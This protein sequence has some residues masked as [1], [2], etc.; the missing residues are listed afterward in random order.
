MERQDAS[1]RAEKV[2]P[3]R[4]SDSIDQLKE[5]NI[6]NRRVELF[7]Q[8]SSTTTTTTTT[9]AGE[10]SVGNTPTQARKKRLRAGQ[11]QQLNGL[12][13]GQPQATGGG[14]NQLQSSNSRVF[15]S[16][17][18]S[19]GNNNTNNNIESLTSSSSDQHILKHKALFEQSM[20]ELLLRDIRRQSESSFDFKQTDDD[21]EELD[22]SD[23]G[24]VINVRLS[25]K[26]DSDSEGI[27]VLG[28]DEPASGMSQEGRPGNE[29]SRETRKRSSTSAAALAVN[30]LPSLRNKTKPSDD[31]IKGDK[32]NELKQRKESPDDVCNDKINVNQAAGEQRDLLNHRLNH[33]KQRQ[34]QASEGDGRAN[35]GDLQLN[36]KDEQWLGCCGAAAAAATAASEQIKR[37][38]ENFAAERQG[39]AGGEGE[40]YNGDNNNGAGDNKAQKDGRVGE[41]ASISSDDDANANMFTVAE[42]AATGSK[43][44]SRMEQRATATA[45]DK[46]TGPSEGKENRQ[47][48]HHNNNRNCEEG[49]SRSRE[50]DNNNDKLASQLEETGASKVESSSCEQ[51]A[52]RQDRAAESSGQHRSE[53]SQSESESASATEQSPASEKD[54]EELATAKTEEE[55]LKDKRRRQQQPQEEEL[56][57]DEGAS[58]RA[59]ESHWPKPEFPELIHQQASSSLDQPESERASSEQRSNSISQLVAGQQQEPVQKK[60]KKGLA[61]QVTKLVGKLSRKF[62]GGKSGKRTLEQGEQLANESQGKYKNSCTPLEL[63]PEQLEIEKE[64]NEEGKLVRKVKSNE[65]VILIK[66]REVIWNKSLKRSAQDKDT[67]TRPLTTPLLTLTRPSCVRTSITS[68]FGALF[69]PPESPATGNSVGGGDSPS[70]QEL[71]HSTDKSDTVSEPAVNLYSAQVDCKEEA[72]AEAHQVQIHVREDEQQTVV[73]SIDNIEQVSSKQQTKNYSNSNGNQTHASSSCSSSPIFKAKQLLVRMFSN[74]KSQSDLNSSQEQEHSQGANVMSSTAGSSSYASEE[75]H[76]QFDPSSLEYQLAMKLHQPAGCK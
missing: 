31:I 1:S 71:A 19:I 69:T 74:S 7:E 65:R 30:L 15:R 6:T 72:K 16:K 62:A 44:D 59:N 5:S 4:L 54:N 10:R 11:R 67:C 32:L 23:D 28:C 12:A 56:G 20:A 3:R 75:G 50:K 21:D 25:Q 45:A 29:F 60:K 13:G 70:K 55:Q 36:N 43:V 41:P 66:S 8:L 40:Q 17:S 18:S 35:D 68:T 42:P 24:V 46:L 73:D 14:L 34:Q 64:L 57:S 37:E 76:R 63:P 26:N 58:N 9:T 39:L 2:Q 49:T 53:L 48:Q 27:W 61:R 22:L 52:S 33:Q 47:R 51:Q 38:P